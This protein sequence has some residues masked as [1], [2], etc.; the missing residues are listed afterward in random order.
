MLRGS[1]AVLWLTIPNFSPPGDHEAEALQRIR[2]V[3]DLAAKANV[4]VVLYP[5]SGFYLATAE[6]A[7]ALV[8]RSGRANVGVTVNL[9]HELA[10][11]NGT[12]LPEIIRK[13]APLLE[14][15]SINGADRKGTDW[16][17][18][19][20]L[21]GEGDYDVAA[22]VRMLEEVRYRGPVGIQFYRVK[23]DTDMNLEAALQAWKS[24]SGN[25][26]SP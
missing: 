26:N 3:A 15:V 17:N 18:Y 14:M 12:R 7:F 6:Q 1:G 19:L 23:G 16:S 2:E 11:G 10:A 4:R 25:Q 8:L 20:K 22:V 5:H 13:V 21:L 9:T 24:L